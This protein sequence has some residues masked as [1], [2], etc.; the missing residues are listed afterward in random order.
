MSTAQGAPLQAGRRP[1]TLDPG[2][3]PGRVGTRLPGGRSY[4]A[5]SLVPLE[6]DTADAT[7][8]PPRDP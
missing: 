8:T 5:D 2:L 1:L 3:P 6:V 4:L 7:K